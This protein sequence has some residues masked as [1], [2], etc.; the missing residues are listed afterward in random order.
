MCYIDF[1]YSLLTTSKFYG[2]AAYACGPPFAK[3]PVKKYWMKV[4]LGWVAQTKDKAANTPAPETKLRLLTNTEYWDNGK[5]NGNYYSR[6]GNILGLVFEQKMETTI[7]KP[8][9]M[10]SSQHEEGRGTVRQH[11]TSEPQLLARVLEHSQ[12]FLRNP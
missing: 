2:F 8:A 12:T 10:L 1:L 6:M 5:E 4:P 9:L 7:I 3:W 11:L